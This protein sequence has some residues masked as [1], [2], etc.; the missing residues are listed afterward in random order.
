VGGGGV[1]AAYRND[2]GADRDRCLLADQILIG[3]DLS[4]LGR[5]SPWGSAC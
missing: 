2:P 4:H 3:Y 5:Q 1:G